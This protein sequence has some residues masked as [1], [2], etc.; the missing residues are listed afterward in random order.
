MN[1]ISQRIKGL[2]QISGKKNSDLAAYLKISAQSLQNKFARGSFS[3][4]DLIKIAE[5]VDAELAFTNGNVKIVLDETC[6]RDKEK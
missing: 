6:I 5:F 4:D 1:E 2:L 3:A